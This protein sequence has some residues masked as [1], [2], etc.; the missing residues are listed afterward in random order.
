[1]KKRILLLICTLLMILSQVACT[2][3]DQTA[4]ESVT[5]STTVSV[6]EPTTPPAAEPDPEDISTP[7]FWKVTGNGYEGEFYLLG[8]IHVGDINTNFYPREIT[9]A[10]EKSQYLAV[11]S[12]IIAVESDLALQVKMVQ[13]LMY[14]KGLTIS[15][16]IGTELYETARKIL[17]ENGYYNQSLDMLRPIYWMSLIDS[18]AITKTDYSVDFGVDRYFLSQAKEMKK[19]ILEIEDPIKTYEALA[20]LSPKTQKFLLNEAVQPDYFAASREGIEALYSVWKTGDMTGKEDLFADASTEG[21]TEEEIKAYEEYTAMLLTTRNAAM[22]E[23]TINYLDSGE[24]IFYIV[25]LA[26]MF[27]E[28][29]I[30]NSLIEQGYTVTQ[31]QYDLNK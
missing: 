18:I 6:T 22:V 21:M 4:A 13:A 26:H 3:A 29:G 7:Y 25:G 8:S 1:M 20:A 11:E 23:T 5:E 30:V 12:D 15:D 2:P 9:D 19:P 14:P 24:D 10:F 27:G 17:F 31:V 28:D 16:L